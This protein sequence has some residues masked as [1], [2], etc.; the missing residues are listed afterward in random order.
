MQRKPYIFMNIITRGVIPLRVFYCF[1]CFGTDFAT[2]YDSAV[3]E[4]VVVTE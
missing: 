3:Q 1:C 4:Y 2:F